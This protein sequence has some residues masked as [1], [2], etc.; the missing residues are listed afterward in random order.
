MKHNILLLITLLGFGCVMAEPRIKVVFHV[1][2]ATTSEVLTN[3]TVMVFNNAWETKQV[4]AEGFC[5]FEGEGISLGWT[6]HTKLEGY[7]NDSSGAKYT[8]INQVL[9]RMEPW[10]P[11][12]EVKM[13]PKINPVSMVARGVDREM[14]PEWDKFVGFDLEIGDW[15]TPY[16]EGRVSDMMFFMQKTSGVSGATCEISFGNK[17]DGIQEFVLGQSTGSEFIFPYLAPTNNYSESMYREKIYTDKYGLK[18]RTNAKPDAEI[19]HLFRV[20]TVLDAKGN[21]QQACYGRIKG[22]LRVSSKGKLYFKYWFNPVPNERSLEYSG[23]NL[24]KK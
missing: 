10:S 16:G 7:Y 9:N 21:V 23:E 8:K 2:D 13:R 17:G 22:E 3:A 11:T 18:F 14:I 5:D 4:D 1:S 24:L 20:R 19:N 15:V 12:V 6:G